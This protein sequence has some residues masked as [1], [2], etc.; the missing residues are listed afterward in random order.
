M[1]YKHRV[2]IS[3]HHGEEKDP[4]SGVHYKN[5]FINIFQDYSEVII[6]RSVMEGD[7]DTSLKTESIRQKIRDEYLRNTTVTVVLIG[8]ETWKRKHV[9]WEISSSLRHTQYNKRSGLIGILL[10]TY[11]GYAENKYNPY[12]IPPRL[13]DNLENG[14]AKL[15]LWNTKPSSIQKWVHEAY[16]RKDQIEPDNSYPNFVNNKSADR[17]SY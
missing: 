17:W 6:S 12:T 2:F 8:P 11:P 5:K 3:F 10:P 13:Y 7:I 14:F 16:L 9:D 1:S 4:Y 15:Y